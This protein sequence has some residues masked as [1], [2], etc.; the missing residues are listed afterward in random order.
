MSE[1]TNEIW[2][3]FIIGVALGYEA[4]LQDTKGNGNKQK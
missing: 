2:V 3:N 4:I 1:K